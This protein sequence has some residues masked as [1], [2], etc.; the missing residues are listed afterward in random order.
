MLTTITLLATLLTAAPADSINGSWQIKGDVS[1]SPLNTVCEIKQ[2][3]AAITGVCTSDQGVKQP[4][5]GDV[6]EG[7]ITFKHGGDYQGTELTITYSGK[8][9]SPTKLSGTVDV[10]PFSVSGTF[11]AE[12]VPAKK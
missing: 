12:P 1:G 2:T 5:T 8:L 6:K 4:I 11:T 3:G 10:A 9:E 7:T